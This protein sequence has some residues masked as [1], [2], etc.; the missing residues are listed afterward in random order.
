MRSDWSGRFIDAVRCGGVGCADQKIHVSW[1]GVFAPL[2]G[3]FPL[4]ALCACLRWLTL[5]MSAPVCETLNSENMAALPVSALSSTRTSVACRGRSS[6][7]V[8][9]GFAAHVR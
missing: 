9:G 6:R 8:S 2:F 1:Y 4:F 3:V 7:A 5:Q